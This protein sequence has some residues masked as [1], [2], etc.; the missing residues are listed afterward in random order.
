MK[1]SLLL[2]ISATCRMRTCGEAFQ[3]YPANGILNRFLPTFLTRWVLH[4]WK[5]ARHVFDNPAVLVQYNKLTGA[6]IPNELARC[7]DGICLCRE[8]V[9]LPALGSDSPT[10]T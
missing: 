2:G 6:A 7:L 10:V 1:T 8:R 3:R 9:A 5:S 4:F